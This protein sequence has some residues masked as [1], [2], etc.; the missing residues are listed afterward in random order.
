[1][2]TVKNLKGQRIHSLKH[3]VITVFEV[4][5]TDLEL[6]IRN[7]TGHTY[8]FVD[9]EEA[10]NCS[11]QQYGAIDGLYDHPVIE[12]FLK[13]GRGRFMTGNLLNYFVSIGV[14]LPGTY[15]IHVSW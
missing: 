11:R 14:I 4:R 1:M 8:D 15:E 7:M 9:D 2:P 5:W 12:E 3:K 13:T 10:N 6:F